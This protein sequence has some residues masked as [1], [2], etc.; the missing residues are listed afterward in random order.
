ML[1]R[2]LDECAT[3]DEAVA[4]VN[5]GTMASSQWQKDALFVSDANGKSVVIESRNG[6]VAVVE[7]DIATN[8]YQGYDD[9]EDYYR[10]GELREPVD[11]LVD[12]NGTPLYRF[13]YGHGYNRFITIAAQLNR[14]LDPKSDQ[15]YMAMPEST[16]LVVLQSVAQGSYTQDTGVSWTQHSALYNNAKATLS[17]WSYMNFDTCYSYDVHGNVIEG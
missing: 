15:R 16:A 10:S 11:E 9:A 4:W 3:V 5:G 6:V 17:V 7:S 12:E 1:R 2:L 13:G 8:F 14:Y